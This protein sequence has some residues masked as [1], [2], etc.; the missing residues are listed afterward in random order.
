MESEPLHGSC[1][2]TF[3]DKVDSLSVNPGAKCV[4][5]L[6]F[7]SQSQIDLCVRPAPSTCPTKAVG[8]S[9]HKMK[10]PPKD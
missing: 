8:K 4:L 10:L 1:I 6:E 9:V 3:Q 5:A 2:N 7:P